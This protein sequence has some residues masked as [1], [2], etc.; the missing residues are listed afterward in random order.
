MRTPLED[1]IMRG[2]R[3]RSALLAV[4]LVLGLPNAALAGPSADNDGDGVF[5]VLDNCSTRANAAPLD[6]DTD[7]DGYGNACDGDFD[8]THT[9]NAVDFVTHFPAELQEAPAPSP[10]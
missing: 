4:L 6:C 3:R 8:Q 1:S 9:V 5:D 7:D 2:R 10:T